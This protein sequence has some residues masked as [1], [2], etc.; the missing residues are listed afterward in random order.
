[1]LGSWCMGALAFLIAMQQQAG[2]WWLLGSVLVA[3]WGGA[4]LLERIA[5]QWTPKGPT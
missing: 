4:K 3:S 1:M 2:A 5:D